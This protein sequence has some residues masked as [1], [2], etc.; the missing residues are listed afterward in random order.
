[1]AVIILSMI[2]IFYNY[3]G[4][5]IENKTGA[6]D[7]I[8]EPE[9]LRTN[10]TEGFAWL[11]MDEFGFN[12]T[13]ENA[14][15][16]VDQGVDIL[17]MG[18]SHMEAMQVSKNENL[19]ALLNN[20]LETL[21]TYNIG[22]SGHDIYRVM[23]NVDQA[24]STYQ[25]KEY[26]LIETDEVE[27]DI[28]AMR[29]VIN[30]TAEKIPSYDS[31]VV[32]QLQKIPAIK[33]IYKSVDEWIHQSKSFKEKDSGRSVVDQE[34]IERN[35]YEKTLEQFLEK[36]VQACEQTDCTPIIF[37][38][39]YAEIQPDGEIYFDI[40]KEYLDL[41]SSV[42]QKKGIVFIN[43]IPEFLLDYEETNCLP[44]GFSNTYVT[45]GHINA[46]GHKVIAN[47]LIKVISEEREEN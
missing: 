5:H 15:K 31:G 2:S 27:L 8:W 45:E 34:V 1:M 22:M 44:H 42:C 33:W 37:Y 21:N 39:Q 30:E 9:Q 29:A 26:L 43:M 18:S 40:N 36:C 19:G 11:R 46:H 20:E 38:H 17:L 24:V 10:M 41:F 14:K 47:K 16:A 23:D 13:P 6:T 4:V 3:T 28:D 35:Y 12:N 32:Y 7:Y 25:P